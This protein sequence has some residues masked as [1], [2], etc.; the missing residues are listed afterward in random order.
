MTM[1]NINL[2]D[3]ANWPPVLTVPQVAKILHISHTKAYQL[4][5]DHTLPTIKLGKNV[6]VPRSRFIDWLDKQVVGG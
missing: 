6:R 5:K 3:N 1:H 4:A 2:N